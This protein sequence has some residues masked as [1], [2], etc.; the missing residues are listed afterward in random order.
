MMMAFYSIKQ[1]VLVTVLPLLL[2]TGCGH[3]HHPVPQGTTVTEGG[4]EDADAAPMR[5][6]RHFSMK[7]VGNATLIDVI[8]P[9]GARLGVSF[10]YLLVPKE[11]A[12]P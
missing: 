6:A 8:R 7:K 12:V 4:D 2:L 1:A 9:K 11:E 3:E 10:R 5:Y